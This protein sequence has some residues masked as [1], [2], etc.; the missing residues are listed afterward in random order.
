MLAF[1]GF[2]PDDFEVFAIPGLGP[3]MA[4]IKERLRP[5]L[6]AIGQ[7][8]A[9]TLTEATGVPFVIH[10][11]RHARRTVNPPDHTWVA[12]GTNPRGYKAH[13]HFEVG[14]C[15]T[16]V[17]IRAGLIYEADTRPA[18]ADALIAALPEVRRA[19][20]AHYRWFDDAD[21]GEGKRHGD[22]TGADFEALAQTLRH[23][24]DASGLAG[25]NVDREE[26]VRLGGAGFLQLAEETC[27]T[28]VP[29]WRLAAGAAART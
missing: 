1:S 19:L 10:V 28:L 9:P 11:A 18:F 12:L 8:L 21:P 4:A 14:L 25:L 7:A 23:R 3:R 2:E 24:R 27:R 22:M 6:E 16:H 17:F 13:P 5:K 20:P 15:A 26:A 29:V